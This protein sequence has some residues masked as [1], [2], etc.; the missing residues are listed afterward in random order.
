MFARGHLDHF[1]IGF[2]DQKSFEQ[3]RH[4][5]VEYDASSGRVRDFGNIQVISFQDPD[6]MECELALWTDGPALSMADSRI[7]NFP[8]T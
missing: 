1:A 5:L 2:A 6:G 4:R 7:E 8:E 3:V